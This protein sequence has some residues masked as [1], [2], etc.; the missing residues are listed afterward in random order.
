MALIEKLKSKGF[1]IEGLDIRELNERRIGVNKIVKNDE[2]IDI[3]MTINLYINDWVGGKE[4]ELLELDDFFISGLINGTEEQQN[5]G[6]TGKRKGNGEFTDFLKQ[7]VGKNK[8]YVRGPTP[9]WE[10]RFT[11]E[12]MPDN[13]ISC[14]NPDKITGGGKRNK[15][16]K[17]RKSKRRK[18]KKRKSK[19]KSKRRKSRTRRRSR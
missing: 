19:R 10:K 1:N 16:Y 15:K 18:S 9:Y 4:Y 5:R 13:M 14:I 7:F 11:C 2:G 6:V 17:R 12:D 8:F 3:P